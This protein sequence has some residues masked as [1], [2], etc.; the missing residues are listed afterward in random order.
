M[1]VWWCTS[2]RDHTTIAKYAEYQSE[3]LAEG[4]SMMKKGERSVNPVYDFSSNKVR[5]MIKF[6]TNCDLSDEKKWAQHQKELQKL[7]AW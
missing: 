3:S 7:P 5:R 6:G 2:S 1:Q 4:F